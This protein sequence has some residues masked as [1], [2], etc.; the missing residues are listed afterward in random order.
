M[1]GLVDEDLNMHMGFLH[2]KMTLLLCR[3]SM[4]LQCK[5]KDL[6][7]CKQHLV[8]LHKK[9]GAALDQDD[10][11]L[12]HRK[13]TLLPKWKIY[14][15][16]RS[17]FCVFSERIRCPCCCAFHLLLTSQPVDSEQLEVQLDSD[18]VQ[19]KGQGIV[20]I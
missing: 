1:G 7:W 9:E 2:K 8:A 20:S 18:T 5:E 3:R 4:C 12:L 16:C 17:K 11:F 14:V 6:P 15:L 19:L 13:N 10:E